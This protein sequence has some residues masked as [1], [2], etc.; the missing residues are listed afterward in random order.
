MVVVIVVV[1]VYEGG[2][3]ISVVV[4]YGLGGMLID[5]VSVE[6]VFGYFVIMFVYVL[7]IFGWLCGVWD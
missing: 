7:V 2:F 6:D 4:C 1:M 3:V 5:E